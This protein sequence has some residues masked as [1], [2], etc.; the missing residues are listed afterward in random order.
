VA[1]TLSQKSLSA[2]IKKRKKKMKA[3][4]LITGMAMGGALLVSASVAKAS[5]VQ[6]GTGLNASGDLISSGATEQSYNVT[7]YA[8]VA[9]VVTPGAGVSESAI[10]A[11]EAGSYVGNV[12]MGPALGQWITPL[13]PS[14]GQP[15]QQVG[16]WTY[17]ETIVGK[18]SMSG[19]FASD[20]GSELL[21]NGNVVLQS[22]SWEYGPYGDYQSLL[23]FSA[24]LPN[25]VNTIEWEVYN[26]PWSTFNPTSLIV[27]GTATVSAVPEPTTII[28]GVLML[29]PF[30]AS[31]LRIL[32]RNRA[33]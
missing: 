21:V 8:G 17:T 24:A 1:L 19:S 32:R 18:G 9:G 10:A 31:T 2:K 4:A 30:G 11:V 23:P 22:P 15:S 7:Y 29:L 6:V 13:D 14:T 3:K 12:T 5:I 26:P 27:V 20:N 33:A 28:S 16:L 25:A